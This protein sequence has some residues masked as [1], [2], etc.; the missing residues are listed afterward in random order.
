MNRLLIFGLGY[1]GRAIARAAQ[2]AG[3]A[4]TGTRRGA[5]PEPGIPLVP[6]DAA[7]EALA[8]ATH[9][10]ATAPPGGTGDM[11]EAGDPVLARYG[12]A[13]RATKNLRWVGYLSTTGVYGDRGG[14]WVDEETPPAPSGP[15]GRRRLAAETAWRAA[16]AAHPL[17][18]A[19]LAGIYGPG[20]SPLDAVRAGAARRILRP[21]HAFG[22]I[23]RAD[24]AAGVLA[25]M[26]QDRPPG[27]RVLNFSDDDPTEPAEV[28]AEAAR[29]LGRPVPEGVPFEAARKTMSPMALSFWAE[30]RKVASRRTQAALGLAWRYPDYRA[31]LSAILA[32]EAA[33]HRAQ[34]REVGRA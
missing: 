7:D 6:F 34:Q 16:A 23:H 9:I 33:D 4:V 19:R 11:G 8:A 24:I 32:E 31:G 3:F 5:E 1:S 29:L 12:E 18:L 17:D 30:N 27:A 20:R 22:R 15:R 2:A 28:I 14:A 26:R 13:I 10:L 25:A 21:G